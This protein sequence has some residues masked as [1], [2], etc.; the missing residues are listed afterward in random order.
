MWVFLCGRTMNLPSDPIAHFATERP[1]GAAVHFEGET[2]TWRG[3]DE[4]TARA[5]GFVE[6]ESPRGSIVVVQ[7]ANH[8]DF[9]ALREAV[10][11]TGRTFA[12]VSP[13]ASEEE[14]V[15]VLRLTNAYLFLRSPHM[16]AT[17]VPHL[18][19][20]DAF[21]GRP[22]RAGERRAE[23]K[24]LLL[25]S[26]TT[27]LP[28]ACMRP[29]AADEA[30]MASMVQSFG[31]H[32]SQT[33]LVATPLYHSGPTIFQRTHLALGAELYLAS[34]FDPAEV[35]AHAAAGHAATAF[36]VPTHYHRLLRHD[37][38]APAD[39]IETWWI[40][41]APA[42]PALK[43]A[44]I[45]RL[46]KGKLWEFLGASETGTVAVMPPAD[47]LR[48]EGSVGKPPPG[49]EVRILDEAGN[50]LRTGE[51]GLIYARSEMLMSGYLGSD[52]PHAMWNDGYLSVGDLGRLDEDGYLY[53][54]DRRTDLI[55][56]GG[57]NVYPAEVEAV[58]LAYPGV[59]EAAV[60]GEADEEW[61]QRVIAV[62]AG[63]LDV[64]QLTDH[65]RERLSPAK[66]PKRVEVWPALPHNAIG[67]PLRGEVRA[68]L[69]GRRA[70]RQ[71]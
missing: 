61:G 66:R 48:K 21:A 16:P 24:T 63:E 17:P 38:G 2:L 37:T 68:A 36:F 9:I 30:R 6:S 34:R 3:L 57:V 44:L 23:A 35:W 20:S 25:T 59:H 41:G 22:V 31:L 26:G 10:F 12:A 51:T 62:V 45:G 54:S 71:A 52:A 13:S 64:D 67:K 18:D 43:S 40:A 14:L 58:L 19:W 15:H 60:V 65:L 29:V 5:C 11:R 50:V 27:G 8:P 53:L 69:A 1:R 56:T 39:R 32:P 4:R 28:K 47:H 70:A 55:I 49:V 33:H 7:G 42:S 46:G